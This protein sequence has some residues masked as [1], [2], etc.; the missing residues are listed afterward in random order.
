MKNYFAFF[1][2]LLFSS[3]NQRLDDNLYDSSTLTSYKHED[4]EGYREL[5][6]DDSYNIPATLISDFF[7]FSKAT[8]ETKETKIYATYIGD[9]S[10]IATDTVIM[11]CHGNRDHMDLYW[12]RAKL[13][14]NTGWKN[15]FGVLMIDYRGYGMSE[16]KATEEGMY[17]DVDA[18]LQWLS[19]KGLDNARLV[20]YGYSLGSASACE[21]TASPRSLVP[22]KLILEAPFAST[23]VMVQDASKLNMPASY[24]TDSKLDNAEK[25]KRVQQPFL[26]LHGVDDSFLSIKTH[27]EVVYKNYRGKYSEAHRIPGAVHNNVPQVMGFLEYSSVILSFITTK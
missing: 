8:G 21:L 11:Y 2:L 27:G 20:M 22:S 5:S 13:L 6:M 18:A 15:R 12:N 25:I 7:I 16:G 19:E 4:Y 10:R 3:C 26:W 24:F 1:S 9:I 23:E 17:A 14:A